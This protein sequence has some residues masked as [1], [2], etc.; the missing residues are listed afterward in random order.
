[1]SWEAQAWAAKQKTGSSSRKLL[2]IYLA[3]FADANHECWPSQKRIAEETEMDRK[4]VI[5]ALA[6]LEDGMFPLIE[7]TG[8]R[9]G[10]TKQ[11]KV[12]R[13][14]SFYAENARK[15]P[16]AETV[17]KTEQSRK[18]N[19][20][21]IPKKRSQKRDTE[22]SKEPHTPST[23]KGVG[24]PRSKF[25]KSRSR[26]KA[27]Q[28]L[29]DDW[30]PPPIDNLD[31]SAVKFVRQWPSGAYETVCEVFRLHY[32]SEEGPSAFQSSWNQVLSKW[33][34]KDHSK[35]MRDAKAGVSFAAMAPVSK[36][37]AKAKPVRIVSKRL[38]DDRSE[39]VH[40]ILRKHLGHQLYEQ[41]FAPTAIVFE[42]DH[43]SVM[44]ASEFA[45]DWIG[46]R[47]RDRLGSAAREATGTAIRSVSIELD[48]PS[49]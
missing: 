46:D 7:D 10:R 36:A 37:K 32:Q 48:R 28:R 35:I 34:I 33:L 31:A 24:S 47:F 9:K 26:K 1:M 12:Y 19:S 20:S 30:T 49:A 27:G 25:N 8:K 22:P 18:R 14:A 17:P 15:D 29:P 3:S 6:A 40:S 13:L 16:D 45:R 44:V 4:T 23:P 2:L 43:V 5:D 41:W 42:D 21:G 39:R 11:V 38:E